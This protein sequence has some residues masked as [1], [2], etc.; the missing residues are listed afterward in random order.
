M[1][2]FLM[3][4]MK[5]VTVRIGYPITCMLCRLQILVGANVFFRD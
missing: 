3:K 1:I 4:L 5:S 2:A